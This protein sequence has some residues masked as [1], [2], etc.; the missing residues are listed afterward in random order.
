MYTIWIYDFVL[1]HA[2]PLSFYVYDTWRG[3]EGTP[4]NLSKADTQV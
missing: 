4:G 1:V 3:K 2:Y